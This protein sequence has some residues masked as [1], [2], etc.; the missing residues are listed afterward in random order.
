MTDRMLTLADV[1]EILDVTVPTARS[2]VRQGG[3]LGFQVG[4]RGMWR[5]EAKELEA[6]VEREKAAAAARLEALQ[7]N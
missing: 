2:L 4:G 5:I 3:I 1:A 6:Y 7:Q